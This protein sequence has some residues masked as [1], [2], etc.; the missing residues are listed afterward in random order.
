VGCASARWIVLLCALGMPSTVGAGG[1]RAPRDSPI[2]IHGHV[3]H[4]H[5][6]PSGAFDSSRLTSPEVSLPKPSCSEPHTCWSQGQ[7]RARASGLCGCLRRGS[8]REA[9][10]DPGTTCASR[11]RN[12]SLAWWIT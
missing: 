3:I 9:V 4:G 2:I 8:L 12:T 11:R 7:G 5:V 6:Q 1:A 10:S